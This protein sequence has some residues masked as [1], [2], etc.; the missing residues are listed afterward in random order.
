MRPRSTAAI[1]RIVLMLQKIRA[2]FV[3]QFVGAHVIHSLRLG[4]SGRIAC[5]KCALFNAP[6]RNN[7]V[8]GDTRQSAAI[9]RKVMP[10][11]YLLPLQL[12]HQPSTA[13][14]PQTNSRPVAYST[15]QRISIGVKAQAYSRAGRQRH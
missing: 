6:Q 2:F 3:R 11:Y 9:G 4:L 7:S 10:R 8:N 12:S 14:I 15:S 5:R 13:N 1:D